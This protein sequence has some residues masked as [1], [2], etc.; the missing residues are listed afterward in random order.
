MDRM[1]LFLAVALFVF[2]ACLVWDDSILFPKQQDSD[3][4][5]VGEAK[6]T[7]SDVRRKSRRDFSWSGLA[8]Q[9][10]LFSGDSLFTG[11]DSELQLVLNDGTEMTI[12]ENTLIVLE[13]SSTSLNLDLKY[14][15]VD[16]IENSQNK[17]V[18]NQGGERSEFL[19]SQKSV[20]SIKS[21]EGKAVLKVI[22][23]EVKVKN[24]KG[25]SKIVAGKEDK[26]QIEKPIPK[27]IKPPV[28]IAPFNNVIY[29]PESMRILTQ[30]GSFSNAPLEFKWESNSENSVF[31]QIAKDKD[32]K[33]MI[34]KK[35][36]L[37]NTYILTNLPPVGKYFWRVGSI[38]SVG[39]SVL[40]S[41]VHILDLEK[42]PQLSL[43][44]P[45]HQNIS[46]VPKGKRVQKFTWMANSLTKDYDLEVA[47]DAEF[48][49]I[50]FKVTTNKGSFDWKVPE[51]GRYHWR[52]N[53]PLS[54]SL[55]QEFSVL[56]NKNPVAQ[57]PPANSTLI[58][59][60]FKV[61]LPE[62]KLEDV[63]TKPVG[64]GFEFKW[65][66][67]EFAESML[68]L[69]STQDFKEI[70]WRKKFLG[71]T[72]TISDL[73]AGNFFWRVRGEDQ[74]HSENLISNVLPL[75]ILPEIIKTKVEAPKL[76]E[77]DKRFEMRPLPG[78]K[79]SSIGNDWYKPYDLSGRNRP[80]LEW[81]SLGEKA[82]Y[83][84]VISRDPEGKNI[85]LKK[86]VDENMFKWVD[87]KPGFYYW[88]V[89]A[90][91]S[92][93]TKEGSKSFG[94]L[95]VTV[96]PPQLESVSVKNEKVLTD[97]QMT[98]PGPKAN[99]RWSK[100]PLAQNY[101]IEVASDKTFTKAKRFK[102]GDEN[103]SHRLD[104]SGT[105]F[106]RVTALG[107]AGEDISEAGAPSEFTFNRDFGLYTP[108]IASPKFDSSMVFLSKKASHLV[109][110]WQRVDGAT[111]YEFELSLDNTFKTTYYKGKSKAIKEYL[112]I[113][114]PAGKNF[115]RIRAISDKYQSEWSEPNPFVVS[116][117]K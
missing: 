43:T 14:G 117:G 61:I 65:D 18:L 109:L 28:L 32:F 53:T 99:L 8:P 98:A 3:S 54:Q 103:L 87:M 23:G 106:W 113:E 89:N 60:E 108:V 67:S 33:D 93:L 115:W 1:I 55:V 80:F 100:S 40:N 41:S 86:D 71:S 78:R 95:K 44:F 105:F 27:V 69:S 9:A 12:S 51:F 36:L 81:K 75:K 20:L 58:I 83:N 66:S 112:P 56:E 39:R 50:L 79:P 47:S 73:P 88:A 68:E 45:P 57:F 11:K 64:L 77:A 111:Q 25:E 63:A 94:T 46:W 82:T 91:E 72:A 31:L 17:I 21:K 2:A 102:S 22:S 114:L 70:A 10:P 4:N 6:I 85:V 96:P 24:N 7:K 15:E 92:T 26:I 97:D 35:E 30:A 110:G 107:S 42:D 90:K 16:R 101:R 52:V 13:K 37:D 59:K 29:L 104:G 74:R 19:S 84:L 48:K 5:A 62:E 116:Y 49:N 38:S 76:S 34:F